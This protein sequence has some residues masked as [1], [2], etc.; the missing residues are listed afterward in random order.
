MTNLHDE[1]TLILLLGN[2]IFVLHNTETKP[3]YDLS[4]SSGLYIG[5]RLQFGRALACTLTIRICRAL[6]TCHHRK[7]FMTIFSK[8]VQQELAKPL[9]TLLT[10]Q[11]SSLTACKESTKLH[12]Q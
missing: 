10:V 4:K 8:S 7:I 1:V 2:K 9:H 5:D 3:V 11:F 6:H 12:P